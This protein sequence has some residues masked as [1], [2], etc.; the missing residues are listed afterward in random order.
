MKK[1]FHSH[2][3]RSFFKLK[4]PPVVAALAVISMAGF[5]T[6]G[7]AQG[8]LTPSGAPMPTMKSLD[9]IEARTPISSVPFNITKPGSY[10]L[11]T[12]FTVSS[13]DAIDI[14]TNGVTLDLNG[15]TLFSTS[16]SASG[17]AIFLAG[18]S[19]ITIL[20][21]H[22]HGGVTNDGTNFSGPGFG[23]G[24]SV[25]LGASPQNLR[26][27]G[28]SVSGCSYAGILL[29]VYSSTVV[30]SCTVENCKMYGIGAEVISHSS[31]HHCGLFGMDGT[32]ISDCTSYVISNG[33]AITANSMA[34]GCSGT[35]GAGGTGITSSIANSCY[36]SSGDGSIGYKY[37]MP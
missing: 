25:N 18:N 10:Y 20:N 24:I 2:N 36:S 16:P 7:F 11:T 8:N 12:N 1:T 26:V 6:P 28:V 30:E 34:I 9:Q 37:N 23:S 4:L 33:T 31:A 19:D 5:Q 13:G 29:G 21:G 22:I 27:T 32:T 15:F 3:G 35:C 17:T 14:N